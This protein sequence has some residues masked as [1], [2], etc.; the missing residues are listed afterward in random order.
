MK[1]DKIIEKIKFHQENKKITEISR[2]ISKNV[3]ETSRGYILDYSNDFILL[4][5]TGDFL[6]LSYKIIPIE[7]IVKL[8]YNEWDKYYDKI[9]RWEKEIDNVGMNYAID[10]NSWPSVFK[11][12][13]DKDL[14]VIVECEASE[15]DSYVIGPIDRIGN[16]K[17]VIQNFDPE[18]YFD[19]KPTS[20]NYNNITKVTFDDRYINVFM[21]YTRHRKEK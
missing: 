11:S 9:F 10:L 3:T 4:H 6:L 7:Q 15:T 12:I 20:I 18:G 14:S 13:K 16:K 21:K 5:S 19:K 1:K 8:R 17:V 2:E